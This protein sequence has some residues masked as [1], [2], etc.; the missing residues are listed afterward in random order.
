MMEKLLSELNK[1]AIEEIK[2]KWLWVCLFCGK[3][4]QYGRW[5]KQH[6]ESHCKEHNHLLMEDEWEEHT[7]TVVPED[8]MKARYYV[9]GRFSL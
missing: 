1:I 6:I 9:L 8:K 7:I 2:P 5:M 3:S 4:S